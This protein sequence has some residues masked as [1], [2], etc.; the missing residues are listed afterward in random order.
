MSVYNKSNARYLL[1][2]PCL[3][4]CL[5]PRAFPPLFP[6]CA[7]SDTPAR[8]A[9]PMSPSSS[10]MKSSRPSLSSSSALPVWEAGPPPPESAVRAGPN[11]N[12]VKRGQRMEGGL[13]VGLRSSG[14]AAGPSPSH[15]PTPPH[16]SATLSPP[17]PHLSPRSNTLP[18]YTR[19]TRTGFVGALFWGGNLQGSAVSTS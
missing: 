7:A 6:C 18:T 19:L 4:P 9:S 12:K 11:G 1:E 13:G 2:R 17:F 8:A 5:P 10:T 14:I 3:F 16:A 15:V